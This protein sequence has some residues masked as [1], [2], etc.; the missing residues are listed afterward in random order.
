MRSKGRSEGGRRVWGQLCVSRLS[1]SWEDARRE[2]NEGWPLP[3]I[4]EGHCPP[5]QEPSPRCPHQAIFSR[6]WDRACRH[7]HSRLDMASFP[8]RGSVP[9]GHGQ[10]QRP[11]PHCP[12]DTRTW[13]KCQLCPMSPVCPSCPPGLPSPLALSR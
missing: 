2:L 13:F 11:S 10:R 7:R 6:G 4:F 1:L 9:W 12:L 5:G 3:T 8:V